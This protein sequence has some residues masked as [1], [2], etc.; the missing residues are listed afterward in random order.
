MDENKYITLPDINHS[1]KQSL[2]QLLS[3]RRST[4]DF[5]NVSLSLDTIGQLLWAAQGITHPQGLRT[6][7]SAGA[8]YPL[9]LYFVIGLVNDLMPG[10]YHYDPK[11]HSLN[12]VASGDQRKKLAQS[13]HQQS[14]VMDAAAVIVIAAVYERTTRKYGTRGIRYVHIETGHAAQNTFLQAESLNLGAV[15]VGAFDDDGVKD[16]LQLPDDEQPLVLIP[17]GKK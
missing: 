8:L 11:Q 1:T 3:Q 17:V 4:R 6:A 14:W 5:Q 10:V 7:P 12:K 9:E 2:S 16:V 15:I 13:A